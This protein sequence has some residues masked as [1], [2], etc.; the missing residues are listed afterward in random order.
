MFSYLRYF[1]IISA[2]IITIAAV[3]LGYYFRNSAG[4]DLSDL[5]IKNNRVLVQNFVNSAWKEDPMVEMLRQFK[6]HDVTPDNWHK[7]KGYKE[8]YQD[9]SRTV[10]KHFEEMPIV[11]VN[12]YDGTGEKL[13]S[14][15]QSQIL[16]RNALAIRLANAGEAAIS[17]Q[18]A[19]GGSAASNILQKAN[20]QL[21]DGSRKDGT[22]VQTVVPI[23]S[24]NYVP[25][26]AGAAGYDK[27]SNIEG[28]IEIYYDIT[29]QWQK[30]YEF[31]YVGTGAILLIFLLLIGT[32]I[33]VAMKAERIIAKQHDAN[34]ELAAQASA[35]ETE[36]ENKSQFL[37]SISHELRTPLNAIIGFSEIIKNETM[38][39]IGNV[40][41]ADYIRDIH[42][43]GVHLLSL[44]N[45][46]LDY[47]KAEAGKLELVVE[48]VD[49]TKIIHSSMRL[50]SPRAEHA[51]VKLVS[52]VPKEHYTL[53]TDGKK[54][55]QV[56]LNLLSN[57]VKFTPEGG[58]IKVTLWQDVRENALSVE[59]KDSGIGIAPKD[60][61]KALSPFGQVDSALSRKYEGT[62]LG[63]PLTK[64]F[65]E[66]MNG[67]FEITSEEDKGTTI[68]FTLPINNSIS[69][70]ISKS[71]E[72][73]KAAPSKKPPVV[74]QAP[75]AKTVSVTS[76]AKVAAKKSIFGAFGKPPEAKE[77]PAEEPKETLRV[78]PKL[79][80]QPPAEAAVPSAVPREAHAEQVAA[81][82]AMPSG[83]NFAA[84]VPLAG[85]A[86]AAASPPLAPVDQY[87]ASPVAFTDNAP[88]APHEEVVDAT[89]HLMESSDIAE[90]TPFSA[91]T[92]AV[93][94][95]QSL[96]MEEPQMVEAV[97]IATE[98]PP[99][100]FVH[101]AV[102]EAPIEQ[103]VIS[104]EVS[105]SLESPPFAEASQAVQ[106]Y[107]SAIAPSD[108][109]PSELQREPFS[110][111]PIA[112]TPPAVEPAEAALSQEP[113]ATLDPPPSLLNAMAAPQ[114]PAA[115]SEVND[116][117]PAEAKLPPEPAIASDQPV[118][119]AA[120]PSKTAFGSGAFELN[121]HKP[122]SSGT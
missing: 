83:G 61:S 72:S 76:N 120:E 49:I 78:E 87:E 91:A 39:A 80:E 119:P 63:L 57:A 30:L 2:V 117:P 107:P 5:V 32:L 118:R 93:E 33:V 1:S 98:R 100:S 42:N 52:E 14:L 56:L 64:K 48:E 22:L 94:E 70:A 43:S 47:S 77:A 53:H 51:K 59:V 84:A 4:A 18:K 112:Q 95:V 114:P 27:A 28:T 90:P 106:D 109:M 35:A 89:P 38:G 88:S 62:G 73:K 99:T 41:Y 12:I 81:P 65:V 58:E 9:F 74:P 6:Q 3:G 79:A 23:L 29:S 82:K 16:E 55:K 66:I 31:Q 116:T 45:D 103:E 11:H 122:N 10:F 15:N 68:T 75:V 97:P 19:L 96:A 69:E 111:P 37:A 102:P 60:I 92:Q 101:E 7:Y 110:V 25:L 34:V 50:V 67:T 40:Q 104:N 85:A 105:H 113:M 86:Q 44:I 24:D 46:I 121:I 115:Q 13:L 21:A 54:V 17:V 108:N 8:N 26:V 36:N 71:N 20:F